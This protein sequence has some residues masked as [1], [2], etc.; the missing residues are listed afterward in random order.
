MLSSDILGF[1]SDVVGFVFLELLS[2][3]Q[4]PIRERVLRD[5]PRS[6]QVPAKVQKR[7]LKHFRRHLGCYVRA[8]CSY[9]GTLSR[10]RKSLANHL[11]VRAN[12]VKKEIL[13]IQISR[14]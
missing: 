14:P 5:I 2:K 4:P 10:N 6:R 12:Q 7:K 8:I 11:R 1:F 13:E 9:F 3:V